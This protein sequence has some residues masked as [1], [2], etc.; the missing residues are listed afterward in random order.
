MSL[1]KTVKK[2][3]EAFPNTEIYVTELISTVSVHVGIGSLAFQYMKK[4]EV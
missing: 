4:I 1:N 2:F 3:E